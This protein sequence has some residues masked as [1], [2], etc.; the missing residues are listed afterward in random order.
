MRGKDFIQ[1]K[2]QVE[3]F[4]LP[5]LSRQIAR[6]ITVS[7]QS[8][9]SLAKKIV[10]QSGKLIA[11]DIIGQNFPKSLVSSTLINVI[12]YHVDILAAFCNFRTHISGTTYVG[13]Y[14]DIS[15]TVFSSKCQ[16]HM[17]SRYILC[18]TALN[19]EKVDFKA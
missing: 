14:A 3:L 2:S 9:V 7:G 11:Q 15:E 12:M 17:R 8:D 1:S 6:K 10:I 19:M 4:F 18:Q 5:Q 16:Y 13:S